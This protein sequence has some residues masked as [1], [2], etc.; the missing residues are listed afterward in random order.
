MTDRMRAIDVISFAR[1]S[2]DP[3]MFDSATRSAYELG[4][5]A[6]R[7]IALDA[8]RQKRSHSELTTTD[9]DWPERDR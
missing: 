8:V 7:A 5:E 9:F 4:F 1:L 2:R 3:A 6:M